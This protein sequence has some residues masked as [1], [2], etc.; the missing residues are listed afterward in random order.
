MP[1]GR[2]RT[3]GIKPSHFPLGVP[4]LQILSIIMSI[5][6]HFVTSAYT[7]NTSKGRLFFIKIEK[8][9]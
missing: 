4:S 3:L 8:D 5:N 7:A 2:L 6:S 1:T 9:V